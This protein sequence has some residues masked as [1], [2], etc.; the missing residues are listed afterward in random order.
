[1]KYE[2]ISKIVTLFIFSVACPLVVAANFVAPEIKNPPRKV[3]T[4]W[5][6]YKP[7]KYIHI[8]EF[9]IHVLGTSTVSDWMM[10]E[11]SVLIYHMV[12]ALKSRS[13]QRRFRGHQAFIIT[14]DDPDLTHDGG[15]E[16]HRNTGGKGFSLF[17]EALVCA[18][19]VDTL[20]PDEEPAYRAWDVPV[21]EFGHAIE[22]TLDLEKDCRRVFKKYLPNFDRDVASEY[23]AWATQV[24]FASDNVPS[25]GRKSMPTWQYKFLSNIFDE[26]QKWFPSQDPRPTSKKLTK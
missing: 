20:Y 17:N 9:D 4:M 19:A 3:Q 25:S 24:W 15:D 10:K 6:I 23:F 22:E 1:M 21:H 2:V 7:T 12:R 26:N 11:S 5:K 18:K 16:G 14:D 13:D 8:E